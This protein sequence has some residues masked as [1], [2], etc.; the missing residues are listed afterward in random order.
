MR[1]LLRFVSRDC[2]DLPVLSGHGGLCCII[3]A[4]S[5]EAGL[6]GQENFCYSYRVRLSAIRRDLLT[7]VF[8]RLFLLVH[9]H[10]G[11]LPSSAAPAGGPC[12]QLARS[13][14]L[15]YLDA[16]TLPI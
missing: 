7:S 2:R 5:F 1:Q 12:A 3:Y 16:L 14:W 15:D 4:N 6:T 9:S 13:T 10:S 11:S 8:N